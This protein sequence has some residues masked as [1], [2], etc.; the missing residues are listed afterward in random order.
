L[1]VK[2]SN[3]QRCILLLALQ[4]APIECD[5][6]AADLLIERLS[7]DQP[8]APHRTLGDWEHHQASH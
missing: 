8:W 2:L 1:I 6:D 7:A 4:H 5:P 3:Y